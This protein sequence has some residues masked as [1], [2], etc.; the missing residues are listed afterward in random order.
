MLP[1]YDLPSFPVI[2]RLLAPM[3]SAEDAIARLD[4]RLRRS[5]L[6]DG[7]NARLAFAE[8]CASRLAEGQ[9]V[10]LEDLVL[11][12]ADAYT[13]PA[14]PELSAAWQALRTWRGAQRS[15]AAALLRA[16][17]LGEP[18]AV[19]IAPERRA[20]PFHD[21]E[22]DEAGRLAA[23]RGVLHAS[24]RL[25]P[26]L[27]AAIAWDAWLV[28]QPEQRGAWRAP[29]IAALLLRAR[30]KTASLLL[31]IAT[32]QRFAK[33]R[34]HPAHRAPERLGGFLQWATTA[35]ERAGK[36]LDALTLAEALLRPKLARKRRSSRLQA[37]T[38]LLL[39]RPLVSAPMAARQLGVSRQ[40][41][42][43]MLRELGSPVRELSG[44]RRYRVWGIL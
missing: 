3:A 33:Y 36:E 43:A 38:A 9:L 15:D 19:A 32:G 7:L 13:G 6:A 27:A 28:L 14:A 42:Q 30:R 44:R 21:P 8:A 4:E 35:A 25:P 20:D 12:D 22:W 26:M 39:S 29:L 17:A 24:K 16:D 18:E 41:V 2:E 31:P 40:A 34:R 37:L 10:H 23:W 1:T 5:P 11:F